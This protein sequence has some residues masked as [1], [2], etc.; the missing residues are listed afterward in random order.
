MPTL[1]RTFNC[2]FQMLLHFYQLNAC[3]MANMP[4]GHTYNRMRKHNY[5]AF[6]QLAPTNEQDVFTQVI[7]C[8]KNIGVA[9]VL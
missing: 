1:F 8:R 6:S 4:L 3:R 9:S 2:R 5:N 7:G